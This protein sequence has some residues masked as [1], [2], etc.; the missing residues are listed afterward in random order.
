M[1]LFTDNS[2][3]TFRDS[4]PDAVD[5]VIIGGGVIGISTAWY[6]RK[7][8]YTVLVCDKG[9]VAGEQS[10]R[11]WGWIRV[12]LRDAA[13]VP[14]AIDSSRCWEEISAE[15]DEDIGFKREGAFFLRRM[16]AKSRRLRP[17]GGLP[18]N[19]TA[20]RKFSRVARFPIMSAA[21]RG[22]G[23]AAFI[24]R[25]TRALN[26]LKPCRR[27]LVVYKISAAMFGRPAPSAL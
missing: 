24:H 25:V 6:L 12:T 1:F 20:R 16:K 7:L 8:G 26:P 18:S 5:V 27:W 11:N 19:M 4:L 10:S 15:L 13:E 2:P 21:S 23:L 3:V 14:V 17:G 22:I 9:R